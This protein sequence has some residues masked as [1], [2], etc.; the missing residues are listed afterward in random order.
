MNIFEKVVEPILLY[1]CEITQALPK[2]WTYSKF[3]DNIWIQDDQVGKVV[4]SFLRLIVL[5]ITTTYSFLSGRVS[6]GDSDNPTD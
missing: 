1:N 4:N 5:I 3:K 2:N 6:R